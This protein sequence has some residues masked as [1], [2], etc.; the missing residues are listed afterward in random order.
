MVLPVMMGV[1]G[2]DDV[3]RWLS[4]AK[5]DG[6]YISMLCVLGKVIA[7]IVVQTQLVANSD[8]M[9]KMNAMSGAMMA[10]EC[11]LTA[12]APFLMMFAL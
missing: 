11:N 10:V 12:A 1:G 8:L 4:A 9:T 6:T 5:A 2:N 7:N 3:D